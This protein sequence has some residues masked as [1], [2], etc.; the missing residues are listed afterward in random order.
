MNSNYYND[1][2]W[3]KNEGQY[4]VGQLR[5][6]DL[7]NIMADKISYRDERRPLKGVDNQQLPNSHE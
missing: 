2:L 5:N 4:S 7:G 1:A 3:K 6:G